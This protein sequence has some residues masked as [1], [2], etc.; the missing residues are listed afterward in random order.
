MVDGEQRC[1]GDP[2]RLAPAELVIAYN[3]AVAAQRFQRFEVVTGVT[4][5]SVEQYYGCSVSASRLP[6][7]HAA[8]GHIEVC[9]SRG[10][11]RG[12]WSSG[13]GDRL[14]GWNLV[15]GAAGAHADG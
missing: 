7:P 4:R 2:V 8:A 12:R 6:V 9:L 1:V 15:A 10:E 11:S 13:P 3:R 14:R 5:T